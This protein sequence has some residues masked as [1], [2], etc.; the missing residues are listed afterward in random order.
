[1]DDRKAMHGGRPQMKTTRKLSDVKLYA[2][3]LVWPRV[4]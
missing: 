1:M 3:H 4:G 2:A